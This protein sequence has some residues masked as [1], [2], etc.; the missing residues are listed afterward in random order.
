M[1][2]LKNNEN[3]Q[4]GVLYYYSHMHYLNSES[5]KCV[6]NVLSLGGREDEV[7]GERVLNLASIIKAC[8]ILLS[9]DGFLESAVSR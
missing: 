5:V 1:P 6:R 9:Y 4:N 3:F 2:N 8:L 7:R